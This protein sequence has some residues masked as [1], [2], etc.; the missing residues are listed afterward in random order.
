MPCAGMRGRA[1]GPH[2]EPGPG[3]P[4]GLH[5]EPSL[6]VPAGLHRASGPCVP[7]DQY[8]AVDIE[9][10]GLSFKKE[11]IIEIGAIKVRE[12]KEEDRFHSLID[13]RRALGEETI[14]LTGLTDQMLE[15]SPGIEDV[16]G[17]LVEFCGDLP[18]L[19][20]RILFDYSFLKKAAVDQRI[21]WER[22]GIDTL[23]LCRVF[24]PPE[25]KKNLADACLLFGVETGRSHRAL[26]DAEAAHG[27]YQ[28]LKER[29][30]KED[31]G[32]FV[33]RQLVCKVKRE[34]PATKRQKQRLQELLKYHRIETSMQIDD[35][36][37]NEASRLTDVI[38]A[39]RGRGEE[40]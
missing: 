20:H 31:P 30:S 10:T 13:P 27:L 5:R 7:A 17:E 8:V 29:Y 16:I 14:R 15:G 35:L 11:K 38:L 37:R 24:M 26:A 34:Q 33:P 18:L 32:R 36:T 3:V 21:V 22:E 4:A 40:P 6:S 12:G 28:A 19:G 9:T 25:E 2:R 23:F 39:Q 1:A